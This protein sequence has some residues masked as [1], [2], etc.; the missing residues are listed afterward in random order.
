MVVWPTWTSVN[1]TIIKIWSSASPRGAVMRWGYLVSSNSTGE[2]RER[3]VCSN[4]QVLDFI[5]SQET[6]DFPWL[7]QKGL[8][9][10][11]LTKLK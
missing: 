6:R 9:F 2:F 1:P 8:L 4:S 10:P 7:H 11:V 3:V 5:G